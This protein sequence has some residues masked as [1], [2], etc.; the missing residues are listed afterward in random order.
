MDLERR[1]S[2]AEDVVAAKWEKKKSSKDTVSASSEGQKATKK[3]KEALN[4]GHS[5]PQGGKSP[6]KVCPSL[7]VFTSLT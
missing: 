3:P 6:L 1:A 2:R 7:G 4:Q 5:S